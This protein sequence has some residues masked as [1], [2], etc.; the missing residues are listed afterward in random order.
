MSTNNPGDNNPYSNSGE[1]HDPASRP[2]EPQQPTYGQQQP[3]NQQPPAYGSPY[4]GGYPQGQNFGPPTVY[5]DNKLGG[6]ALGLG[7]ASIV[8]SCGLLTGIPAIIVGT[9]GMRAAKEGTAN[10]RGMSLTGVVIG[11]VMT[12]L[13]IFAIVGLIWVLG[14]GGGWEEFQRG[15][16]EGLNEASTIAPLLP[17]SR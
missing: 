3:Y 8:L 7:L 14:P 9:K 2:Q 13:S 17:L 12:V 5:P 1:G 10:N 4:P 15:F 16:E 11:I 6:W